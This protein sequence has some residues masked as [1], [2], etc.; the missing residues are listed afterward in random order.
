M[1]KLQ[2]N[3]KEKKALNKNI[4]VQLKKPLLPGLLAKILFLLMTCVTILEIWLMMKG[5]I[6][7]SSA[8]T[9]CAFLCYSLCNIFLTITSV[10]VEQYL[11]T[12]SFP[13]TSF[14]LI[15]FSF[16]KS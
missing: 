14:F 8:V 12:G 16:I 1:F 4:L 6:R 15:S 11:L 3:L 5:T 13:A 10:I 2:S 9:P 7:T